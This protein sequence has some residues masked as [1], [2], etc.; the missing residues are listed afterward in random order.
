MREE[1]AY[2]T[3]HPTLGVER[4]TGDIEDIV[5]DMKFVARR[6]GYV[7]LGWEPEEARQ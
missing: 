7:I 2:Y 3:V 6:K 1:I 4:E 5:D